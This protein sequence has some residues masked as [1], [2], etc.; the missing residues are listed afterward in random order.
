MPRHFNRVSSLA[1]AAVVSLALVPAIGA[2]PALA[3]TQ[4]KVTTTSDTIVADGKC[5]LREAVIAANTDKA[6][7]GCPA[8]HGADTINVPA[9]TYTLAILGQN[10]NAGLT[11]DL[12]ITANVTIRGAGY[13]TTT[14]S[15]NHIDRVFQVH[16]GNQVTIDGLT[17]TG[18]Q[19]GGLDQPSPTSSGAGIA[20][21]ANLTLT[22]SLVTDNNWGSYIQSTGRGGGIFNSGM[23]TV[24][25]SIVSHNTAGAGGGVYSTGSAYLSRTLIESNSAGGYDSH[26]PVGMNDNIGSDTRPRGGDAGGITAAG[27]LS[28]D[29][30][31]IRYNDGGNEW[32]H[33]GISM[34]RGV[35]SNSIIATNGSAI[36]GTGGLVM[37]AGS[38]IASTVIGNHNGNC[39]PGAG[40]VYAIDS[41][42]VN[43]TV[44]SNSSGGLAVGGVKAERTSIINST[45]TL[46]RSGLGDVAFDTVGGLDADQVT[47]RGTIVANNL[48]GT[49]YPNWEPLP[50]CAGSV[51]SG[52]HNL[53]GNTVGCTLTAQ[54]SDL[55]N[56]GAKLGPIANNGGPLAGPDGYLEPLRTHT[57]LPGSPAIDAWFDGTVGNGATCP[58]LDQ[59]GVHRPQDGNGDGVKKCDIGAIE[60]TR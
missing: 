16:A 56:V 48:G 58:A 19:L 57:L 55:L 60:W 41:Q 49:G 53:I 1:V 51:I 18:G 4:I 30:S 59:R 7:G 47:L 31:I 29:R 12:D 21:F 24:R 40:G 9:G 5:S 22:N 44:T 37:V 32:G 17:V 23:L 45:I 15:A 39:G 46:N 36:C 33:G 26:A 38:L 14:I 20:N 28:V 35:V 8:G 52:G 3:G 25:N 13:V 34:E 54:K 6:V 10:E 11:G 50:D 43:S 42:I 2:E 27:Y